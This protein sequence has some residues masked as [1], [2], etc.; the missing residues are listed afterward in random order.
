MA[1]RSKEVHVY[2]GRPE[3]YLPLMELLSVRGKSISF[4]PAQEIHHVWDA[5]SFRK[6]LPLSDVL[7]ANRGELDRAMG[8]MG[9]EN[10]QE[11]LEHVDMVV[12]TL[13]SEGSVIYTGG[14]EMHIPPI[15]PARVVDTTGAGDS[16]RAGFYAGRY[17]GYDVFD[18]AVLGSATSSFAI[19]SQ[20]GMTNIPSWE[21]V[22]ERGENLLRRLS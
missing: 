5:A 4:D 19:E 21:M 12:N 10:A 16:F 17:R 20:G 1:L 6:A 22:M 8:Y 18:C 2:T 15:A 14:E 7:F 9:V 11:L 3:Y 13:G